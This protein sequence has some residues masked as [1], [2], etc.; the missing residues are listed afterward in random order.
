MSLARPRDP[1]LNPMI[2]S[3]GPCLASADEN[4]FFVYYYHL[5][6][7]GRRIEPS[8]PVVKNDP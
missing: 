5:A 7:E 6:S 4:L 8:S 1:P 3:S 2:P